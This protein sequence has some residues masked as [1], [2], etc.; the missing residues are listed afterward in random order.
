[1]KNIKCQG[2]SGFPIILTAINVRYYI[3][4]KNSCTI[5]HTNVTF[6]QLTLYFV[7]VSI[8]DRPPLRPIITHAISELYFH[9][10]HRRFIRILRGKRFHIQ[11]F[12]R[13]ISG[14]FFVD[15]NGKITLPFGMEIIFFATKMLKDN[16]RI[17]KTYALIRFSH[18][19]DE[20]SPFQIS[21]S[22]S[23]AGSFTEGHSSGTILRRNSFL[24]IGLEPRLFLKIFARAFH[25]SFCSP[26]IVT[27][28]QF[29]LIF[30]RSISSFVSLTNS[31]RIS[32]PTSLPVKP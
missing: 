5:E 19:H 3:C 20:F 4:I 13:Q 17:I 31:L 10:K 2:C 29:D 9:I 7:R 21:L 24:L 26:R 16:V 12:I 32:A 8:D 27:S 15:S 1:M 25:L 18:I 14:F 28:C 6:M 23:P 11:T 22:Q 30:L